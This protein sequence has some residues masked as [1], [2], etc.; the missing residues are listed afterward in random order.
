MSWGNVRIPLADRAFYAICS[1]Q[2]TIDRQC[3]VLGGVCANWVLLLFIDSR[4]YW[5]NL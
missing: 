1:P 3:N 2:G 5:V 4:G